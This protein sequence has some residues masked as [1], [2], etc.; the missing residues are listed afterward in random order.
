M[1]YKS[2]KQRRLMQAVAHNPE[3]AKKVGIPQSV[4]R[5]F[6]SHKADGGPVADKKSG[7]ALGTISRMARYLSMSEENKSSNQRILAGLMKQLY[8]LNKDREPA[9]L[10]GLD[11][12]PNPGIVDEVLALPNILPDRFV[13]EVSKQAQRD[14][15]ELS[16]KVNRDMGL[17]EA[18][19]FKER[20]QEALGTMLG[21][22]PV[23]AAKAPEVA[24]GAVKAAKGSK[25][26]HN[27][28]QALEW[29]TPSVEP[30]PLNYAIGT[31]TG[32]GLGGAADA[33]GDLADEKEAARALQ[34]VPVKKAG[35]GAVRYF[36]KG[37]QVEALVAAVRRL[38]KMM[39]DANDELPTP[40]LHQAINQISK[41]HDVPAS[42]VADIL[43][44][45]P[46]PSPPQPNL[47]A[48]SPQ[49]HPSDDELD[50]I[51]KALR[52]KGQLD[53][54]ADWLRDDIPGLEYQT[55]DDLATAY[56]RALNAHE[57]FIARPAEDVLGMYDNLAKTFIQ[58]AAPFK[59]R[60]AAGGHVHKC[61]CQ[62]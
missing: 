54:H 28:M 6:E 55:R 30:N 17:R 10:G 21:Q 8:G 58:K 24:A 29:F 3:F 35:G 48:V 61:S 12:D 19:G 62:G 34:E 14:L 45:T 40:Q 39:A 51:A 16:Q 27:F 52:I 1:P 37:G 2:A 36:G 46:P 42:K 15:D 53:D 32:G 20:G 33:L 41:E 50:M 23:A 44:S 26:A 25:L 57:D 49:P 5:K 18:H 43:E 7:N 60:M 38:R 13:P 47:M 22:I 31:A 9:F 56:A 59:P 11:S 4:G